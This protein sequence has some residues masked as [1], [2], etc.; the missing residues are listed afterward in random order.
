MS[1]GNS[2]EKANM[3]N[4]NMKNQNKYMEIRSKILKLLSGVLIYFLVL[5]TLIFVQF[6]KMFSPEKWL[7]HPIIN[8]VNISNPQGL[9]V[10]WIILVISVVFAYK[11]FEFD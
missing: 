7:I 4:L 6:E 8:L 2:N 3:G 1:K 10:S 5:N 11:E 9:I